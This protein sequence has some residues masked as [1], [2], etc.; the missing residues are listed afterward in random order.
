[1]R[2]ELR[3]AREAALEAAEAARAARAVRASPSSPT[4]SAGGGGSPENARLRGAVERAQAQLSALEGELGAVRA[5]LRRQTE[6]RAAA[7]RGL[8]E[9]RAVHA[10]S[11]QTVQA[12]A[13]LCKERDREAEGL[14]ARLRRER[15]DAAGADEEAAPRSP[16]ASPSPPPPSAT[17]T[18][19]ASPSPRAPP[20]TPPPSPA[21]PAAAVTLRRR[22][23]SS[24][25]SLGSPA[26][27][28]AA[29]QA[30]DPP[31]GDAA[32][33][34]NVTLREVEMLQARA[35]EQEAALAAR[36]EQL[37]AAEERA[38]RLEEELAH[39]KSGDGADT[40]ARATPTP[41]PDVPAMSTPTPEGARTATPTSDAHT[42]TPTP[43]DGPPAPAADDEKDRLIARLSAEL[44]RRTANLQELVNKELWD[45]NRQIERLQARLARLGS[46]ATLPAPAP[47]PPAASADKAP[48]TPPPASPPAQACNVTVGEGDA[49]APAPTSEDDGAL[50]AEEAALRR[51]LAESVRERACLAAQLEELR[52]RVHDATAS[53]SASASDGGG[54]ADAE[55]A[56]TREALAR[57]EAGRRDALAACAAL[58]RRLEALARALPPLLRRHRPHERRSSGG[59]GGGGAAAAG[60][61]GGGGG[62]GR[63]LR[64]LERALSAAARAARALA[65]VE[66]AAPL[67]LP[68]AELGA[69]GAAEHSAELSVGR[70]RASPGRP[71]DAEAASPLRRS[72]SAVAVAPSSV[73]VA[74]AGA[75]GAGVG[76]GA[77]APPKRVSESEVDAWSE[78]DRAVSM[79]RVGL[80]PLSDRRAAAA[81]AAAVS[82]SSDDELDD[83]S[84]TGRAGI[85]DPYTSDDTIDSCADKLVES[86]GELHRLR[87]RVADLETRVCEKDNELL[88][89]QCTLLEMR[90]TYTA[91]CMEAE[92]QL[93][94][95]LA[96][97][98]QVQ[99]DAEEERQ[100]ARNQREAEAER[101]WRL[102]DAALLRQRD[103]A[104]VAQ[105]RAALERTQLMSERLRLERALRREE[106]AAAAAARAHRHERRQL[107]DQILGLQLSNRHLARRLDAAVSSSA[108][109]SPC[110]SRADA[111]AAGP[112]ALVDHAL[113][114][115]PLGASSSIA[116]GLDGESIVSGSPPGSP[117]L[118]PVPS[119]TS[120]PAFSRQ[121]SQLSGY[122]SGECG[123]T[124]P[125][126]GSGVC[127]WNVTRP[128]GEPTHGAGSPDLGI[129]SDAGRFSSLEPLSSHCGSCDQEGT[130]GLCGFQGTDGES[131]YARL[132]KENSNL[133]RNLSRT[134][135]LLEATVTQLSSSN[136]LKRQMELAICKQLNKTQNVLKQAKG[137]CEVSVE[138]V[139]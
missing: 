132:Q 45:K 75:E 22:A 14:R 46:P 25:A 70:L 95:L 35:R 109:P 126:A 12:L 1:M 86:E 77:E 62:G 52:R 83:V 137:E 117:W 44:R 13:R 112:L 130:R 74:V 67:A 17:S 68:D 24:S 108:S 88:E 6:A 18:P 53:A 29:V 116:S 124:S 125:L 119:Q 33:H 84:A 91:R 100:S 60:G 111:P 59:G 85:V 105:S 98:R 9:G 78:P 61:G 20:A 48:T 81:A 133:K 43:P 82:A 40:D 104:A 26:R 92:N 87:S 107:H 73:A 122:A 7:E 31:S 34:A 128:P 10:K 47:A 50:E 80:S 16:S 102:A 129:E 110:P 23:A 41:T 131:E 54:G 11:L 79:A 120:L 30:G 138:P 101:R 15:S 21:D 63:R 96:H 58:A 51:Q 64:A 37:R 57:A 114:V 66:G 4:S 69:E 49:A 27:E 42:P 136:Q 65:N 36:D 94:E 115:C 97:V 113:G 3:Q 127:S 99:A 55:V 118:L 5:E 134:K 90:N 135:K 89:Q 71:G 19:P 56:A 106:A 32:V 2:L 93:S 28:D 139:K 76:A 38:R 121:H 103:A 123:P 39:L 72:A 8:A